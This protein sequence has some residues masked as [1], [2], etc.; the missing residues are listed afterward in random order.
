VRAIADELW[1]SGKIRDQRVADVLH[2][3]A[4]VPDFEYSGREADTALSWLHRSLGGAEIYFVANRQRRAEDIVARFRVAGGIPEIWSPETR[5]RKHAAVFGRDGEHTKVALHLGP[6]ES[7]FVVFRGSEKA[8][9]VRSVTRNGSAV[10]STE[11]RSVTP[12]KA[13]DNFTMSVWAKPDVDLR[14]MP[15]E[16]TAGWL[17]ETGKFYVIPADEGD[18]RFGAGHATAGLAVGRNGAFVVERTSTSAPAVLV[19][20]FPIA[21]WTHFAVVYREGRPR[22]YVNGKF[23]REGLASGRHIHSGVASPPPGPGTAYHFAGLDALLRTSGLPQTPS[24][25]MAFYFDGNQTRPE[26][27]DGA[28]GDEAIAALA[29]RGLPPPEEPPDAE[30]GGCVDGKLPSLVWRSGRYQID[31][32]SPTNVSVATPLVVPG[33]WRVA[34]QV[35]RGA[36]DLIDLTELASWHRHADPHVRH[37]PA[38]PPIGARS[39]CPRRC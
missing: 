15:R 4:I 6:A 16:A 12:P 32:G 30:F 22:L 11:A 8:A 21:G 27:I 35:G 9:G 38:R 29:G 10:L 5:E 34:F 36:P 33:P 31:G 28:L 13:Q 39:T 17:D 14:V 3:R 25:G 20:L 18:V 7:V 23:V 2:E 19:A 26:L 24:Q 37:F 1:G